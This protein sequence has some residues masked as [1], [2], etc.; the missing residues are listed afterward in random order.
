MTSANTIVLITG[1]NK[2]IGKETAR[3]LGARGATVLIGSRD[4]ARGQQAVGELTADGA[5]ARFVQLDVTDGSS[6]RAAAKWIETEFG[7]LDVLINNAGIWVE[8]MAPPEQVTVDQLRATYEVNV[9]GVVAVTNALLPLLRKSA[10]ARIVNVST[11]LSSLALHADPQHHVS[12]MR[13][14]AYNSSKTALNAITLMYANDLREDGILVNAAYPGFVATDLNG[15][16]GVLG[17]EA[18]AK[19]SVYLATLP[20]DGPTGVFIGDNEGSDGAAI[21]PW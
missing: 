20:D 16:R 14:L 13:L 6:I 1:A 15:H 10:A 9:Y 17:V 12:G 18:G 7:R 8:G 5:D 4:E 11:E 19:A 2:G 3:Q 21:V